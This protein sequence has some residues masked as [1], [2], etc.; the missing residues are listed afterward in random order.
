MAELSSASSSDSATVRCARS[1]VMVAGSSV[2]S[3]LRAAVSILR[4]MAA[5]FVAPRLA[6]E[7]F[8]VCAATRD[9]L[10]VADLHAVLHVGEQ[11][12][13]IVAIQRD[14]TRE[15]A[16]LSVRIE[17]AHGVDRRGVQRHLVGRGARDLARQQDVAQLR[18]R[19]GFGEVV[20][21]ARR[22][23]GFAVA[24]QGVGGERDHAGR[25][26]LARDFA[27]AQ[28][29]RRDEAVHD[30]HL[31]VHEH[32]VEFL[33]FERVQRLDAVAGMHGVASQALQHLERERAVDHVV[34]D[35]E[36]REVIEHGFVLRCEHG[37]RGTD[38]VEGHGLQR[39]VQG[40]AQH[41]LAH[42]LREAAHRRELRDQRSFDVV[43]DRAHHDRRN[44]LPF[45]APANA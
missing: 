33:L 38:I 2:M 31:A 41:A 26:E 8:N 34:L 36:D 14:Q 7:L 27:F 4:A 30:R 43:R 17:L 45:L 28:L 19:E 40:A 42:G 39:F 13:G 21:H 18:E 37:G 9:A 1:C 15:Q 20:V 35:Q 10:R 16:V 3:P 22:E 44:G 25:L 12:R 6:L 29:A 24:G 11:L 5:T 32:H 23:A